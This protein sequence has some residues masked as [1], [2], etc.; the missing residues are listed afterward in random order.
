[1]HILSYLLYFAWLRNGNLERRPT[2]VDIEFGDNRGR[3]APANVHIPPHHTILGIERGEGLG[4]L[5]LL[6]GVWEELA[7]G[8]A[9]SILL[10]GV[11]LSFYWKLV[12]LLQ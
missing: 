3:L 12:F 6:G 5:G 10:N 9:S 4:F 1:M 8:L 2:L 7:G 11:G